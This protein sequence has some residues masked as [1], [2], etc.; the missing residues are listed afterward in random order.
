MD[1]T[2]PA[3]LIATLADR[4]YG[5]L[6]LPLLLGL[7]A[8]V[9]LAQWV[10]WFTGGMGI[11]LVLGAAG[12]GILWHAD[13]Q[14]AAAGKPATVHTPVGTP[15]DFAWQGEPWNISRPI[16]A[17]GLCLLGLV[18]GGLIGWWTGALWVGAAVVAVAPLPITFLWALGRRR[19]M[20]WGDTALAA[21]ALLSGVGV[22]WG[23][24][25]AMG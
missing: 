18:W 10:D 22:L 12:I 1:A 4:C 6:L 5:R 23:L 25:H 17:L 9:A 19:P 8:A 24:V 2:P 13:A 20:P 7:L 15:A 3:G 16:A 14:A 21:C 11:W